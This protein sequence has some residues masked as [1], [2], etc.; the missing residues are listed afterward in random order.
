MGK[1]RAIDFWR[2]RDDFDFILIDEDGIVT[3]SEGIKDSFS[4]YTDWMDHELEVISE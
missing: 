1:D 4:L 3:I 2:N